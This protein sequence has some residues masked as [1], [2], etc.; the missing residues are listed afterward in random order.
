[1]L[2]RIVDGALGITMVAVCIFVIVGML[3]MLIRAGQHLGE[4][5]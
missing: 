2:D 3:V 4:M 5:C 1:M